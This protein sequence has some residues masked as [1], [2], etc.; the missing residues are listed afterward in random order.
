MTCVTPILIHDL[1][2]IQAAR[3]PERRAISS[4]GSTSTY[5]DLWRQV[6]DVARRLL[7]ANLKPDDRV[8]IY[9]EKR[10][11]AVAAC[12]GTALA[13]GVFVPINPLLRDEQ[14]RH[15][16]TDCSARFLVTSGARLEALDST[17][18]HG[19][20]LSHVLTVDDGVIPE[21]PDLSIERW[22]A[23]HDSAAE[24]R[25]HRRIDIDM[26]AILYTSGSTGRPKGVVLSHRNLVAGALSVNQYLGN[27]PE[28][29]IL[30]ALPLSFDAGLSQL[31]T[32]F[33]A[34][35][36]VVL[37]NYLTARDL[38]RV[39]T[40]EPVTALTGVPPLWNQLVQQ[41]WPPEAARSLRYFAN[42]GGHLSRPT[43]TK[44]R[45]IFPQAKPFLMYGLTEAFRSTYLDPT[46]VDRRPD[47]I[48]KAIPNAEILVVGSNGRLCGPGEE[49]ELVHRGALVAMGYWNDRE[50]TSQRFRPAPG[51]PAEIPTEQLAVWS[52]DTVRLDEEGFIYFVGRSDGMIKASGYRVSPVEIE[53][54][55]LACDTVEDAVAIGVP[56]PQQGQAIVVVVTPAPGRTVDQAEILALCREKLPLFMVP[57][58]IVERHSLP[59]TPSGKVDRMLLAQE[60]A[61]LY[62]NAPEPA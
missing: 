18:A 8:A 59:Q 27:T 11:E 6:N 54:V 58:G 31:T 39:C 41:P 30:A 47:S 36:T 42:T 48:G 44:L 45:N 46:E 60:L 32:A 37:H 29:S 28:D 19:R 33:A 50:R 17:L 15:I 10:P 34:G 49:G 38:V 4:T 43:L 3:R 23:S 35:A 2:A 22:T 53:E 1:I 12:F 61:T 26:A 7:A 62:G 51:R 21:R 52:G 56:H 14:V 24:P 55:A 25:T 9:L 57:A 20:D 16:V 5:E 40:K 13:G